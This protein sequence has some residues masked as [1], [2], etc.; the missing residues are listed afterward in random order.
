MRQRPPRRRSAQ[1]VLCGPTADGRLVY[2]TF[3]N[4]GV[5]VADYFTL[6]VDTRAFGPDLKQMFHWSFLRTHGEGAGHSYAEQPD[7]IAIP[8]WQP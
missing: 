5:M 4:V 2:P 6:E 7:S 1:A 8:I 3:R